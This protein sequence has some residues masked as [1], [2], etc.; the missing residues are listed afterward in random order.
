MRN[1][2]EMILGMLIAMFPYHELVTHA[3]VF[4]RTG[5]WEPVF[6]I[7]VPSDFLFMLAGMYG[8]I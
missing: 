3:V 5:I 6:G 2:I 7:N 8:S 1:S 4:V